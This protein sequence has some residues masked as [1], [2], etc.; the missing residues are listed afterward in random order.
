MNG[1]NATP[2]AFVATV[3]LAVPLLKLPD[4]PDAG[5]VNVTLT[6]DTGLLAASLTVT[7]SA[8]AKAVLMAAD[9]G[10]V[11]AFAVIE[12]AWPAVLVNAKL[13]EVRLA[14]AAAML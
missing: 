5:P 11:P 14:A 12:A 1:A 6:P 10:V 3:R 4:A 9:C 7:A 13:T 8:L 2:E